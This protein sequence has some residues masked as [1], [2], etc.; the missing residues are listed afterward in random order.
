M[1]PRRPHRPLRAPLSPRPVR[2]HTLP[3]HLGVRPT[4]N[5]PPVTHPARA[6]HADVHGCSAGTGT[7]ARGTGGCRAPPA[8][9]APTLSPLPGHNRAAQECAVAAASLLFLAGARARAL[10]VAPG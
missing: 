4:G 8:Q 3:G 5:H 9:P 10:A 7:I 1:A 6:R 2:L